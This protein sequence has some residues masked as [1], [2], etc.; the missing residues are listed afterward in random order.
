SVSREPEPS[1]LSR[2]ASVVKLLGIAPTGFSSPRG[3]AVGQGDVAWLHRLANL[4][5][6]RI[7]RTAR[8]LAEVELLLTI[9]VLP[10]TSEHPR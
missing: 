6:C 4:D 5:V 3:H 10:R 7:R 9:V 8:P 1:N 2:R